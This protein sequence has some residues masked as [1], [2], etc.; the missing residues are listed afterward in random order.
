MAG[1]NTS[2]K[3]VEFSSN[4]L[5][6]CLKGKMF[7]D[8][9]SGYYK[10]GYPFLLGLELANDVVDCFTMGEVRL[11]VSSMGCIVGFDHI[12]DLIPFSFFFLPFSLVL[13]PFIILC[14]DH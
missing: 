2:W 1:F 4:C 11:L 3:G 7:M 6:M 14:R 10:S 12:V 13:L 8:V 9:Y 5:F